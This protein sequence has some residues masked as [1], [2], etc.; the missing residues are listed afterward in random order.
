LSQI[1]HHVSDQLNAMGLFYDIGTTLVRNRV[2]QVPATNPTSSI[3]AWD[4]GG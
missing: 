2:L 1:V 3:H 4:V